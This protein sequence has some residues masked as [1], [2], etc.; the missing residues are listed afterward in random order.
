[1]FLQKMSKMPFLKIFV[2]FKAFLGLRCF[3][4]FL[5]DIE[6]YVAS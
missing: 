1:M 2:F 5:K 3:E 4:P 6:P